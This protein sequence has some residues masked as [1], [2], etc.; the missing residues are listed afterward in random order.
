MKK[1]P[2]CNEEYGDGATYCEKCGTKL[3]KYR[4]C[5]HCGN[6][7]PDDAIYCPKCGKSVDSVEPVASNIAPA[8]QSNRPKLDDATIAQYKRE[9]SSLKTRKL[10]LTILGSIFLTVGLSL[11]IL[12][13]VLASRE[14]DRQIN[15]N[16]FNTL[17]IT[18]IFLAI[19]FE[20][21]TD[22]GIALLIIQAAVFTKKISN[23]ERAINEFESRK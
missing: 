5:P 16:D 2:Q 15:E 18:Y 13:F 8:V 22:A 1:C 7:V 10:T 4:T 21:M 20:L 23:R 11:C 12:F 6:T 17:Y 9:L 3:V 19:V 14:L